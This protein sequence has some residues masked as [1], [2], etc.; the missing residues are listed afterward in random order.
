[1]AAPARPAPAAAAGA[2]PPPGPKKAAPPPSRNT[3][4]KRASPFTPTRMAVALVALA[5]VGAG[6]F[7][8]MGSGPNP[9][10]MAQQQAAPPPAY[11][12]PEVAPP[13]P[14]LDAEELAWNKLEATL[15]ATPDATPDANAARLGA[16]L[17]QYPA[18]T[19]APAARARLA[20]L[21]PPVATPAPAPAVPAPAASA[22]VPDA[23]PAAPAAELSANYTLAIK[24]WG[25]VYVDGKERGVTPPLKRLA[26]SAGKHQIRVVN[27]NF[28]TFTM[29]VNITSKKGGTVAH[30]FSAA[31]K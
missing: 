3:P 17:E 6:L 18:G 20:E 29:N 26:L 10:N 28:P 25:T 31:R 21:Q 27:P 16:F 5:G 4:A 12:E 30:D 22:A 14:A 19:H 1:Q 23:A 24:P 15:S 11:D 13:E 8:V 7:F 9:V 2:P